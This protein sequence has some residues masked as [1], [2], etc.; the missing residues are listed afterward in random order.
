VGRPNPN[1]RVPPET[2]EG[3]VP[4]LRFSFADAHLRREDGGWAREVTERE[5]P[6]A[7]ALAGVNMCLEAG[8]VRELHWHRQ[9]EWAFVLSGAARITAIDA[10]GR[11]FADDVGEGGLWFFPA[12]LPHSIQALAGGCEF[13]LVFDDG[14]FSEHETFLLTDW[15]AHTPRDVLARDLGIAED[16]LAGPTNH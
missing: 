1:L 2:D 7:T 8:A 14:G 15:L 11:A 16:A 6:I 4:N 5:L 9:A 10:A 13:L 12:G 3:T